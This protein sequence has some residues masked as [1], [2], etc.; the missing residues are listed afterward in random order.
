MDGAAPLY[1]VVF[2]C[3]GN[4]CR[5]PMAEGWLRS[6]LP[7]EWRGRVTVESCGTGALP[8][9]PATETAQRAARNSGFDISRHRSQPLSRDLIDEADL[10]VAME[11]RHRQSVAALA[12]GAHAI[13][14]SPDG[15]PDP[16]GGGLDDYL[17]TIGLIKQEMP[18]VIAQL[19]ELLSDKK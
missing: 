11:E 3:A 16:I 18:D 7:K 2:V 1:R 8:D 12:T 14:L 4:T 9:M 15:V 13:L 6:Q 17:D 5:S 10:I 19:R